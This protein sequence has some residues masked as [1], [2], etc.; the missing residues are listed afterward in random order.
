MPLTRLSP[1]DTVIDVE[2]ADEQEDV[3]A[4][5]AAKNSGRKG[6]GRNEI[7]QNVAAAQK[8]RGRRMLVHAVGPAVRASSASSSA[9]ESILMRFIDCMID[10]PLP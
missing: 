1:S 4:V 7:E 6:R 8:G 2:D 9:S 10:M 5:S 3:P